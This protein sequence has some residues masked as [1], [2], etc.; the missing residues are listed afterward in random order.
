MVKEYAADFY[1]VAHERHHRLIADGSARARALATWL[2]WIKGG[3]TDVRV[4]AVDAVS[5][6]RLRVG[7]KIAVR[8]RVRLG[9]FKPDDVAVQLYLGRLDAD[10]QLVD[11]VVIPMK[12]TG[13][14][15]DGIYVFE[16]T[17]IPCHTSGRHGYTLR[18]LPFQADEARSFLPGLIR[19]ADNPIMT[20]A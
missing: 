9:R 3:W 20:G 12:P 6:P 13:Q 5:G 17:D 15:R 14:N 4:E 16:A 10:D 8:A 19:W 2:S 7:S 18:I 1:A 11:A